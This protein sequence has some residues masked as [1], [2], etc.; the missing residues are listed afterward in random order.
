[1]SNDE[2]I[3]L[4]KERKGFIIIFVFMFVATFSLI[5]QIWFTNDTP[6][7]SNRDGYYGPTSHSITLL[8]DYNKDIG[9]DMDNME[10]TFYH[11]YGHKIYYSDLSDSEKKIWDNLKIT[12]YPSDYAKTNKDENFAESFQKY[13]YG[14]LNCGTQKAF[15]EKYVYPKI[16]NSDVI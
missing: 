1:M 5:A 12:C 2:L 4:K 10:E 11:E 9:R 7:N 13:V 14:N 15:M 16:T 6:W 3:R 8:P